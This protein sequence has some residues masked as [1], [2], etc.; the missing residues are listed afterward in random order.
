[1]SVI[2]DNSNNT[3]E[4]TKE[5][6]KELFSKR[7]NNIKAVKRNEQIKGSYYLAS[8]YSALLRPKVLRNKPFI[9]NDGNSVLTKFVSEISKQVISET[10]EAI[11]H[12]K[13]KRSVL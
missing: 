2:N 3:I 4:S 11:K 6:E 13:R 10:D 7:I 1:M 8:S 12:I 9:L 5:E